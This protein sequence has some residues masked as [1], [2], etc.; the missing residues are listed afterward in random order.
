MKETRLSRKE[1]GALGEA[2][3]ADHLLRQGLKLRA[4]NW[5]CRT[6]EIDLIAEDREILVFIEVRTRSIGGTF[7]TPQESVHARKQR[8]VME[9]AQVYMHMQRLQDKQVRFDVISIQTDP[10]GA[11]RELEHIRNAF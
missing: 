9:T 1:L 5:R 8:Q 7:G 4:R 10:A 3:A 6:G 11:V 2:A